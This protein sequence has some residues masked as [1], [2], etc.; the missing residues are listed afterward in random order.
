[1]R[2]ITTTIGII[3]VASSVLLTPL[4]AQAEEFNSDGRAVVTLD[5][6]RAFKP[7]SS[8]NK[9]PYQYT[10]DATVFIMRVSVLNA[11]GSELGTGDF[12]FDAGS[13][14]G[15]IQICS[16]NDFTGPLTLAIDISGKSGNP[17]SYKQFPFALLDQAPPAAPAPAP[18]APV[19]AAPAPAP[20]APAPAAPASTPKASASSPA[21]TSTPK[22]NSS[23][24]SS[25]K[26]LSPKAISRTNQSAVDPTALVV[27]T[28]FATAIIFGVAAFVWKRFG[29][30]SKNR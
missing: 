3:V 6:S 8:C 16:S 11:Y 28:V 17:D 22:S 25:Q 15:S 14:S 20:A 5:T 9:Y 30:K 1:M 4:A 7:V 18:A 13:G 19:P 26:D 23:T 12:H 10:T 2:K 27:F 24:G 21:S 29:P